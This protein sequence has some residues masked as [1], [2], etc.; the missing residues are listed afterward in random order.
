[1]AVRIRHPGLWL[2]IASALL[3]VW[4]VWSDRGR[5]S[6]GPVSATHAQ[7]P[8]LEQS[9][10]QCHGRTGESLTAACA[11]CHTEIGTQLAERRGFHGTLGE[12]GDDCARC[13]SEHHGREFELV[14]PAAFAL[15]GVPDRDAYDHAG[16]EFGLG[17]R[18]AALACQDCHPHAGDALLA[19]GDRRFV[20]LSQQC[21]TCHEDVHDGKLPRCDACHGQS[22][23]FDR[24]ANFAHTPEFPL[25]GSHSALACARCHAKG[26]EHAVEVLAGAPDSKKTPRDCAA[27]HPSPHTSEFLA[28][29]ARAEAVAPE[30]TCASCH[31]VEHDDFAGEEPSMSRERHAATGFPLDAPHENVA[32]RAC[33]E[34]PAT[35]PSPSSVAAFARFAASHSG[36]S[37]D[38]CGACH[39]DPHAG[40]FESGAWRDQGCLACHTRHDFV[41]PRFDVVKHA[42]T[43]F[44]LTGS[45]AA[46]A[47]NECHVE[48]PIRRAGGTEPQLARAFHGTSAACS[49]CHADAHAGFFDQPWQKQRVPVA[50]GCAHCH[51]TE[52]FDDERATQFDHAL[53]TR[54][55]L[56]GAHA[57]AR[58]ESCHTRAHEPDANGRT[59]GRAP[60]LD[61]TAA[62]Q[63][64][65]CHADA[66]RGFFTEFLASSADESAAGCS[67][68]H[69]QESFSGR[70]EEFDHARFT[71]FALD[72]AHT[73]AACE[74]CH[75]RA[76]KPD[77]TGRRFGSALAPKAAAQKDC[78]ACHADAHQGAFDRAGQPATIEGRVGC[79]RCHTS[80]SFV[81]LRQPGFD[82]ARW[83]GFA[84]DGAHAAVDCSSCHVPSATRS[85]LDVRFAKATGTQCA[86]CH[87]DPHVGQFARQGRTDCAQCHSA[88][89][90]FQSIR[91]DHQRDSRFALD[92]THASLACS[93]CHVP[94]SLPGGGSA[95]R[96]KPLGTVCGDCHDPRGDRAPQSPSFGG[97][98]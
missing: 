67:H 95:V 29:V 17:G 73:R 88:S 31:R 72:G 46:L 15:A 49:S 76:A 33:H 3:V 85:A 84:L 57:R 40:Q 20:G 91:F 26:S 69:D 86:S 52:T 92:E 13:H 71:G 18:H 30:A 58:C 75:P 87:D 96:Y 32:C 59:F 2:G 28:N 63:C 11:G 56:E 60:A 12:D 21:A 14:G 90:S 41:P 66:H 27:C 19:K 35:L 78:R 93:A 89:T 5:V 74:S 47:C 6:P 23:S 64:S 7:E 1:V 70:A 10:D 22:H 9:C 25:I 24:V 53:W 39:A 83:T 94:Q 65:A 50:E 55:P 98:R 42:E 37:A 16:L 34:A 38:D 51:S 68:C 4:F 43:A 79:L 45:H 44:P 81:E 77:E 61:S 62:T 54:M 8:S 36:R 82:H 97:E 80:E 48:K